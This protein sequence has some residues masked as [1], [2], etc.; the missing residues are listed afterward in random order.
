MK[1]NILLKTKCYTIGAMEYEDGADWRELVEN[2]LSPRNI[3]VFNPYKKPFLNN[4]DE[5]PDV[6]QRMR[7]SMMN[8]D[9]EKVTQWARDIRRYDLNLVDRSD[10]IIANINPS[11]ASWGTAEELSTA[12]AA[13]KPIFTIIQGGVS[14]ARSGLW[15]S[16]NISICIT[17]LKMLLKCLQLLTMGYSLLTARAGVF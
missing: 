2:T 8:G 6:R 5:T 3:T 9:Y 11:V 10:F 15:A 12:V 7:E 1:A 16:L 13:R 4:C 17:I 14:I